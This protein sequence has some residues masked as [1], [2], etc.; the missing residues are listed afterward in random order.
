MLT[1]QRLKH[2]TNCYHKGFGLPS[3]EA[4]HRTAERLSSASACRRT[5]RCTVFGAV[6]QQYA[7]RTK[8]GIFSQRKPKGELGAPETEQLQYIS[9]QFPTHSVKANPLDAIPE[10]IPSTDTFFAAQIEKERRASGLG[11]PL[12]HFQSLDSTNREAER[13]A[14]DGAPNGAMVVAD[15]QT[16]GRGRLGRT[17]FDLA[18]K[19]LLFTLALRPPLPPDQ[20][21]TITFPISVALAEAFCRLIPRS[22]VELKWPNDVLIQGKKAAGIL[23]EARCGSNNVE[24]VLAG[25]GINVGGIPT[26]FPIEIQD[27]CQT[28]QQAVGS[29][30]DRL[31]VLCAFLQEFDVLYAAFLTHGL[32]AL[33]KQ[34]NSFFRMK[35]KKIK[36]ATGQRTIKGLAGELGP[37]GALLVETQEGQTEEILAGDVELCREDNND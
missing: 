8:L 27:S 5:Q 4:F 17:W 24:Y 22:A 20:A 25:V 14:K 28:L 31:Q 10:R 7:S 6:E 32:D 29:D 26:E 13:W 37:N 19:S 33:K 30:F 1:Y 34:W 16:M 35:G 2:G 3:T 12:R 23:L 21:P 9:M 36:V 15:H 18:G 11:F